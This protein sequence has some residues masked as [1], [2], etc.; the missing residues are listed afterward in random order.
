M[1]AVYNRWALLLALVGLTKLSCAFNTATP[2]SLSVQV[3]PSAS[4]LTSKASA[5]HNKW[6]GSSSPRKCSLQ[7]QAHHHD[8]ST[9]QNNNSHPVFG[10]S[11]SSGLFHQRQ[12]CHSR[13]HTTSTLPMTSNSENKNND[14]SSDNNSSRN[15]LVRIWLKLRVFMA[16]LWVS[17]SQHIL[18]NIV[19]SIVC[20]FFAL[21]HV[22]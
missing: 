11:R 22:Y 6:S 5:P 18:Y 8:D 14:M 15:P 13:M 4:V 2:S 20:A 9:T 19:F 7:L 16:R 12:H 17:R 10:S 1:I 21:F 3:A